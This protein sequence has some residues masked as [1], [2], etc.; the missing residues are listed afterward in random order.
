MAG[1]PPAGSPPANTAPPAPAGQP[2][3]AAP[4][5]AQPPAAAPPAAPAPAPAATPPAAG[6][7]PPKA[8]PPPKGDPDWLKPRLESAQKAVLTRHGIESEEQ[9][10]Q[11]LAKL[12]ELEDAQKTE[13]EKLQ[14]RAARAEQLEQQLATYATAQM[15]ALTAEQQAAVKAVAGEEPGRQLQAIE[16]LRPTWGQPTAATLPAPAGQSPA[17]PAGTP[18]ARPPV[19]PATTTHGAGA[20]P[21]GAPPPED[22]AAHFDWLQQYNPMAAAAHWQQNEA[23]ILQARQARGQ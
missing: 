5:A 9:L 1:T 19:A 17:A 7:P 6:S 18:P 8:D 16:A 20:P 4:P 2:P 15:S 14:E 23:A 10:Q 21:S 13:A 3:A 12:K 11:R 22:P